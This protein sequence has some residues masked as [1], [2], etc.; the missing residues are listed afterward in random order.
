MESFEAALF[1]G[2]WAARLAYWAGLQG[3]VNTRLHEISLPSRRPMP[4]LRVGFAS[5]FHAGPLTDP[6]L[7]ARAFEALAAGA[8]DLV[9]LGG[10]FVSFRTDEIDLIC[11]Q[12]RRLAPPH[13][14]YAVLGNHDL[15]ADDAVIV[16][17]LESSGVRVLVNENVRLGPP[18]EEVFVCGIDDPV[19]GDPDPVNTFKGAEGIRILLMHT[20]GGVRLLGGHRFDVGFTGHIHGG[21]IALPGGVPIILPPGHAG[22]RYAHGQFQLSNDHG[23]LI[24]SK[25]VGLSGLPVRLFATSEV[26]HCTLRWRSGEQG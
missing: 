8:P 14:V 24:V 18:F 12:A 4:A 17:R 5:D 3:G 2:G 20:P 6:R 19:A 7:L 13:G 9:L 21:Q 26:H 22:R 16:K 25:G 11:E 23:A 1:H 15:W 10:D